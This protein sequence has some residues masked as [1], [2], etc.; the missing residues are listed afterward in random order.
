MQL[1]QLVISCYFHL[2]S[3]LFILKQSINKLRKEQSCIINNL[4]SIV[5]LHRD[6][7]LDA[8]STA[9]SVAPRLKLEIRV[10]CFIFSPKSPTLSL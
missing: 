9:E 1:N 6:T 7:D 2:C 8:L 10:Y 4:L 5:E 3:H